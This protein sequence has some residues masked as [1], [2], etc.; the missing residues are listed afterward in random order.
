M[1]KRLTSEPII[2]VKYGELSL[3]GKNQPDFVKILQKNLTKAL[4]SFKLVFKTHYD[5]LEIYDFDL[6]QINA[7]ITTLQTIPGISL[8]HL[9]YKLERDLDL[10]KICVN[11]NI[12]DDVSFRI[13]CKRKDKKYQYNSLELKVL[14]ANYVLTNHHNLK[15]DLNHPMVQIDVEITKQNFL[16]FTNKYRGLNGLPVGSSGKVLVL[17]SGGIDSPVAA[18]Q[19]LKR[20]MHVDFLTFIT[21]PHTTLQTVNKIKK[22]AQIITQNGTLCDSLLYV[23]NFTSILHELN[24]C[25]PESYKITMMRRF[26]LKI[27]EQLCAKHN[28]DA[29]ATGDALGQV[30]SQTITSL[31]TI[32]Q[33]TPD[34][35]ILRPLIGFDKNEII[36][37]AK[38][39]GT[40]TT[41]ILPYD[42]A[43]SLFAPKKP[44]T[45]PKVIVATKIEQDLNLTGILV[46]SVINK[47]TTIYHIKDLGNDFNTDPKTNN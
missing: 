3:K 10:L 23:C 38:T 21:P 7:I 39:L 33:V 11:A 2:V 20:G 1:I 12:S 31:K 27:A 36:N 32:S 8:I 29:I 46:N 17:L 18:H 35:L 14:L 44:V 41:S 28:Y 22:L 15:V 42:D 47:Q 9:G 5:Y 25:H 13:E 30:A 16:V 4:S 40:Y 19:L 34:L 6:T 45:N 24:H 37:Y 26:F 43:C